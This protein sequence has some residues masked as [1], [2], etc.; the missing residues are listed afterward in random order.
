MSINKCVDID[1]DC[2]FLDENILTIDD[3]DVIIYDMANE[4]EFYD[5]DEDECTF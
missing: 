5:D 4:E 2:Y 1:G 3:W